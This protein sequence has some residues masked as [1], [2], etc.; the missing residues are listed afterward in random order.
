MMYLCT[1]IRGVAQ[2]GSASQWGCGGRWFESSHSDECKA[3]EPEDIFRLS[4][5]LEEKETR[6]EKG[7]R[8]G[9]AAFRRF[10][11]LKRGFF[12]TFQGPCPVI[13]AYPAFLRQSFSQPSERSTGIPAR[14]KNGM[15]K[16]EVRE[17]YGVARAG[18]YC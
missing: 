7:G 6:K 10:A 5:F 4:L 18:C 17:R 16:Q 15:E 12:A 11:L 13:N 9:R 2:P 14:E 8:K 1:R 3:R